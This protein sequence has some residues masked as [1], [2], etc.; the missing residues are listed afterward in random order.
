M[1]FVISKERLM[2]ELEHNAKHKAKGVLNWFIKDIN[3][4]PVINVIYSVYGVNYLHTSTLDTLGPELKFI[5]Q[6][7]GEIL[8]IVDGDYLS[9][10][11]TDDETEEVVSEIEI[12]D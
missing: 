11:D 5:L 6:Q 10:S 4:I 1:F 9:S 7:N 3:G 2:K 12:N 8:G